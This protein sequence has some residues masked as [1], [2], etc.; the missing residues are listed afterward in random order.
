MKNFKLL[1]VTSRAYERQTTDRI[2]LLKTHR[3]AAQLF[4]RIR[5][6]DNIEVGL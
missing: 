1:F 4:T 5:K 6:F 3:R 2:A